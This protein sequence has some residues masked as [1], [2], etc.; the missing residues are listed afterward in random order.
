MASCR[1]KA[2][3]IRQACS[4]RS[5]CHRL[6]IPSKPLIVREGP[7]D[8]RIGLEHRSYGVGWEI[9]KGIVLWGTL[10][11]G[12]V[13]LAEIA[14][15]QSVKVHFTDGSNKSLIYQES[16]A[17]LIANGKYVDRNWQDLPSVYDEAEEFASALKQQGFEIFGG[18][19]HKDLTGDGIDRIV[20]NFIVRHGVGRKESGNNRLVIYY[21]GHGETLN[22]RGYIVPVDAPAKTQEKEFCAKA[23]NMD[24][25][26][27]WAKLADAKHVLFIFDSCF[28]GTVFKSRAHE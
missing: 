2:R 13:A 18:I 17:L 14:S 16:H 8:I 28:A 1:T 25:V 10:L 21:A 20:K 11:F 7:G 6:Q 9:M 24:T 4:L 19:V 15:Q 27:S 23:V 5:A 26:V 12:Q 3:S 22:T